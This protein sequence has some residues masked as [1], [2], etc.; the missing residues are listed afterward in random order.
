MFEQIILQADW[1]IAGIKRYM[2]IVY[3]R[4]FWKEK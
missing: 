4:I 2:Y 1:K 3:T